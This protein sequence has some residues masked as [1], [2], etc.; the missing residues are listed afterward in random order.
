MTD[1]Q[2]RAWLDQDDTHIAQVIR[3]YGW[4][5]QYVGGDHGC[6]APWCDGADHDDGPA[7]AYT[8]GLFDFGHPELL[9][10]GVPPGT[11]AGVL[12]DLGTRVREGTNLVAGEL[13][14][15]AE[16]PHRVVP[17]H[18]PNPGEI[19][20]SANRHYRR[21]ANDSVPLLQLSYDDTAGRF[22][23]DSGYAAPEMQPRPGTFTA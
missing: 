6:T 16:W 7:F 3:R 21:P 2:T 12:N 14:T 9:I 19:A 8:V 18:V 11:A 1:A 4:Y 10:F 13:I 17:E 5:I 15:F 23:W 22:P 20:F